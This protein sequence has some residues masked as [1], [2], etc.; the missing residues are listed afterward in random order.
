MVMAGDFNLLP[1]DARLAAA[2]AAAGLQHVSPVAATRIGGRCVDHIWATSVCDSTGA[3]YSY[4]SDHRPVYARFAGRLQ[5]DRVHSMRS[6]RR[7]AF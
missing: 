5:L 7:H 6:Q 2:A 1:D 4:Y 3:L